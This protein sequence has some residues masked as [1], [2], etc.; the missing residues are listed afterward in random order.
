MRSA[1]SISTSL[2]DQIFTKHIHWGVAC[3]FPSTATHCVDF[4]PGGASGVGFLVSRVTEG[5]GVR[6]VLV[7]DKG[8]SAAELYDSVKIRREPVWAKEWSPKL[9]RTL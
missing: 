7:G 2:A 5:R 3:N 6:V 1:A 9:V 8:K 4:G